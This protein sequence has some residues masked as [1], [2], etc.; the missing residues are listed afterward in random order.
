MI[1][2][3]RIL[4]LLCIRPRLFSLIVVGVYAYYDLSSKSIE[5]KETEIYLE[6]YR[7]R[8]GPVGAADG[9][10][11]TSVLRYI[12]A[13]HKISALHPDRMCVA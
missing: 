11:H 3:L 9:N 7:H 4:P 8:A 1:I 10:R 2:N 12:R 13:S 6:A 5:G